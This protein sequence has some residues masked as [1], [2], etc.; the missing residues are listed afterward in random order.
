MN[1]ITHVRA[2]FET[3]APE[4]ERHR[5]QNPCFLGQRNILAT[6]LDPSYDRILEIGCGSGDMLSLLT[7]R[8]RIVVGIDL[9]LP[10]LHATGRTCRAPGIH[11]M[12]ADACRLPFGGESFDAIVCMGVMEYVPHA[13][14]LVAEIRRVLRPGGH[15]VVTLPHGHCVPRRAG[16]CL[17]RGL[18]RLTGR[19]AAEN[20]G[21]Q[22]HATSSVSAMLKEQGLRMEREAFC[23]PR[24]LAWPLTRLMPS[25]CSW[26]NGRL[27][28]V[29]WIAG[30]RHLSSVYCLSARCGMRRRA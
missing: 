19:S 15:A 23:C 5:R 21:E 13:I 2:A 26:C 29:R 7:K 30:R 1:G 17:K 25:V 8:G 6:W 28:S 11:L 24:V 20:L 27:E 18:R 14:K 4:Y 22:F 9:A 12:Q 3:L 10:M 16:E